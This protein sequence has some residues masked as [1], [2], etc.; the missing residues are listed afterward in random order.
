MKRLATIAIVLMAA[1]VGA[2]RVEAQPTKVNKPP[3][4]RCL[5]PSSR[6]L[7]SIIADD[8]KKTYLQQGYKE[9]LVSVR[10]IVKKPVTSNISK[11][12]VAGLGAVS[13]TAGDPTVLRISVNSGGTPLELGCNAEAEITSVV[14]LVDNAG[15]RTK[16]RSVTKAIVQGAFN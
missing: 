6:A 9:A 10:V 2:I 3:K 16:G 11:S 8:A 7:G 14:T 5:F 13:P 1:C 15:V 4:G 12:N